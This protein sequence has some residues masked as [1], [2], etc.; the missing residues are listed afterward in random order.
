[1]KRALPVI[2]CSFSGILLSL[3][4]R[5]KVSETRIRLLLKSEI[6]LPYRC[7]EALEPSLFAKP[8][9]LSMWIEH[10]GCSRESACEPRASRMQADDEESSLREAESKVWIVRVRADR[11]IPRLRGIHVVKFLQLSPQRVLEQ[12]LGCWRTSTKNSHE[13]YE[14]GTIQLLLLTKSAEVLRKLSRCGLGSYLIVNA[15][16]VTALTHE[17]LAGEAGEYWLL[18]E[19][20][21]FIFDIYT[22]HRNMFRIQLGLR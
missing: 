10:E 12:R 2:D 13:R 5:A 11:R 9:E 15:E 6:A 21:E 8:L 4:P 14:C 16:R 18:D 1:M 19:C 7:L 3:R 20:T 17:A 22:I